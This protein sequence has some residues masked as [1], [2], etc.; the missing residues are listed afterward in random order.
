MTLP[1][2]IAAILCV[3]LGWKLWQS[4]HYIRELARS[5][6]ASE[7]FIVP[8][9]SLFGRDASL[10]ELAGQVNAMLAEQVTMTGA[11]QA[12]NAQIQALLGNLREAVVMVDEDN[13]IH[14]VNP[15]VMELIE[16]GENPV[17]KKL[18]TLIQGAQFLEYL[19]DLRIHGPGRPKEIEARINQSSRW[20]EV[21]AAPLNGEG[22]NETQY[23]LFI[24]HDI[25][26][27]K[28]LEKMRTEFVANV[29]HELRTPI[30]IIKGFAETLLEDEAV[31]DP[32][33][34]KRFL[35]K[36]CKNSERLH[37][38]VEDLMLLTR[39]ESTELVLHLETISLQAFLTEFMENHRESRHAIPILRLESGGDVDITAD[40]LRLN[41]VLNNLV[42]NA[43]R[44][45]RGA[46]QILLKT[47]VS[48][49]VVVLTVSDDGAGIPEGDLP[50]IFQRFYRVEKG[51][52]RESGGTGLG[53]SIV[54][55]I[56][57][58]HGGQVRAESTEGKGTCITIT[59][60]LKPPQADSARE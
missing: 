17:G 28:K 16:S 19:R 57:A 3:Y 22:L 30:T 47:I 8:E 5:A 4:R 15:V 27:Q 1:F 60:P 52:S 7:P 34:K 53:L 31:L 36:I 49:D 21:S 38:L 40:P 51:R 23:T 20:L 48:E 59:L 25:T 41:Q 14:S 44:H 9:K 24:L 32:G 46:S 56:V 33:E 2:Y 58:Q 26:R 13:L 43:Y 42:E 45:A 10:D 29:S 35:D 55:H 6:K 39:L 54:K 37:R 11:G 12:Y 50:H 18:D